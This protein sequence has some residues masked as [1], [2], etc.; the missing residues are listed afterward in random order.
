MLI[1]DPGWKKLGS[2]IRDR[3]SRIWDLG[4]WI[5]I[6]DPQHWEKHPVF[7]DPD[8]RHTGSPDPGLLLNSDPDPG[9]AEPD[10][11]FTKSALFCFLST[12]Q[13]P[14]YSGSRSSLQSSRELF[15]QENFAFSLF[16][17]SFWRAWIRIPIY[18][19]NWICIQSE[20][21]M[22]ENRCLEPTVD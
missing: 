7:R 19:P 13:V 15:K 18:W 4:S 21:E 17:V 11:I 14:Y 5:N 20:S 3:K 8:S 2:G 9:F 1:R 12:M 6:P 16:W 10:L 22:V